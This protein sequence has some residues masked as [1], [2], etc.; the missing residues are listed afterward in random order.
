MKTKVTVKL[1]EDVRPAIEKSLGE[2]V[3]ALTELRDKFG[4]D[5]YLSFDTRPDYWGDGWEPFVS[6]YKDRDE[7]LEEKTA[8]EV[9]ET[10]YKKAMRQYKQEQLQKL[11]EDL[12]E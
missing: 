9:R 2:A 1:V 3:V 6:V 10:I 8:R 12:G 5:A 7:T 11:R 4:D